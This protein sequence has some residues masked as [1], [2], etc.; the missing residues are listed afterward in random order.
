MP[1]LVAVSGE[2]NSEAVVSSDVT[3]ATVLATGSKRTMPSGVGP[4][5][6]PYNAP[7]GVRT[8]PDGAAD[9]GIGPTATV[10]VPDAGVTRRMWNSTGDGVPPTV[11]PATEVP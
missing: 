7:A 9:A 8:R 10:A 5:C 3:V 11:G 1:S 2:R 6:G 4:R